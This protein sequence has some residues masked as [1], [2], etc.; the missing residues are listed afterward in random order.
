MEAHHSQVYHF[1][2]SFSGLQNSSGITFR[3][4]RSGD[5]G[6][7]VGVGTTAVTGIASTA[8]IFELLIPENSIFKPPSAEL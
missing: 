6:L 1:G 8:L 3:R 2:K 4:E 7:I 5:F